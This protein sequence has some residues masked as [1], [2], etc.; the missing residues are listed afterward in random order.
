MTSGS[1]IKFSEELAGLKQ[2]IALSRID[3]LA[4]RSIVDE[5]KAH[6]EALGLVV[7]PISGVTR[8]GLEPLI[9]HLHRELQAIPKIVA[10]Q[11]GVVHITVGKAADEDPRRCQIERDPDG[12]LVVTG[13]ALE[14]VI[15][16]T[17]MGN[18]IAVRRL[19]RQLERWGIFRRLKTF[20]AVE[21][22]TVRIR[23][24]EFDYVD[25]D[26]YYEQQARE[27]DGELSA[28][29]TEDLDKAEIE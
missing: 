27:R 10:P 20:G 9:Y 22:D 28:E 25:E 29:E 15:A 7:F 26:A 12:I 24:V 13:K 8:E 6:F 23:D 3:T 4:D 19:Q 17:D 11:T 1:S 2:I 5:L 21:G 14:R 16:M 18:E